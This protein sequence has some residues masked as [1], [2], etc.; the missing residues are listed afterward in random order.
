MHSVVVQNSGDIA[1]P[2]GSVTLEWPSNEAITFDSD[3]S[4]VL[5]R[6]DAG[7][8]VQLDL[9]FGATIVSATTKKP[10]SF[11]FLLQME[12]RLRGY[13]ERSI[14]GG[15]L[16]AQFP[17]QYPIRIQRHKCPEAN[18]ERRAS[19]LEIVTVHTG[20]VAPIPD[21]EVRILFV[22][23][24][25]LTVLSGSTEVMLRGL[26]PGATF[27]A[28]VSVQF[29]AD[30]R[31][32]E[33]FPWRM[34]VWWRGVRIDYR[35]GL[36]R[37]SPEYECRPESRLLW[38]TGKSVSRTEFEAWSDGFT[39]AAL[40]YDLWDASLNN[41]LS[42]AVPSGLSWR[43]AYSG[44][45]VMLIS[46]VDSLMELGQLTLRDMLDWIRPEFKKPIESPQWFS[47]TSEHP[48]VLLHCTNLKLD[49]MMSGWFESGPKLCID[50]PAFA[51]KNVKGRQGRWQK[52]APRLAGQLIHQWR[53]TY[54]AWRFTPLKLDSTIPMIAP[55]GSD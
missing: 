54:P 40:Q 16:A 35:E 18:S 7:A 6:I 8:T 20:T 49:E 12:P 45:V 46:G 55:S 17:V 48:L 31:P 19:T 50:G 2:E 3:M 47:Y 33:V 41:G 30:V 13:G 51:R 32:F 26:A 34:E 11:M 43:G 21:G 37:L 36:L 14:S 4:C 44:P 1:S 28:S 27:D 39:K 10:T 23:D 53:S 42:R 25:H 5:P 9:V 22:L 29:R 24:E 15:L 38:I 52:Y